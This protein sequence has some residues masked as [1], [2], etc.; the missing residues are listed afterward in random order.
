MLPDISDKIMSS[1]IMLDYN[2]L[3]CIY[4]DDAY[5]HTHHI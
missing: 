1:F 2:Y 4:F 3:I 5:K